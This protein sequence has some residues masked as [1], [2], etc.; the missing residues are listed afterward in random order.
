MSEVRFK[1]DGFRTVYE[2]QHVAIEFGNGQKGATVYV[3][4]KTNGLVSTHK[5]PLAA[6]LEKETGR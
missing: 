6:F 2:D 1:D 5:F 4:P 3:Y